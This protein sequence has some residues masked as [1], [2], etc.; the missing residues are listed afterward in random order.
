[1]WTHEIRIITDEKIYANRELGLDQVYKCVFDTALQRGWT[2]S[3]DVVSSYPRDWVD[4]IEHE[5]V[6]VYN[7]NVV[8]CVNEAIDY[9]NS[10]ED[11][12]HFWGFV[13]GNFGYFKKL[14]RLVCP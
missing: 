7:N 2:P 9:L 3:S 11:D 10:F 4:V 8:K 5:G 6:L 13:N 12:D 14:E 1:M